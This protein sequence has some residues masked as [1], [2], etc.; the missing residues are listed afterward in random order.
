MKLI[1]MKH[2]PGEGEMLPTPAVQSE[3]PYGLRITLNEAQLDALG[4]EMPPA[5]TELHIEAMATVTRSST[6]D[7]DADGDIDFVCVEMQLTR[8]GVEEEREEPDDKVSVRERKAGKLYSK[9]I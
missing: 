6:E 9:A 8:L 1:D 3:Y 2:E 4:L 7:P 5:G